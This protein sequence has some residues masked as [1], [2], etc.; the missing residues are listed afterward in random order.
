MLRFQKNLIIPLPSVRECTFFLNNDDTFIYVSHDKYKFELDRFY[1]GPI[2]CLKEHK[3]I[4]Y[5][6][7]RDGG[8]TIIKTDIGDLYVPTPFKKNEDSYAIT[9]DGKPFWNC[10]ELSYLEPIS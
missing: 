4:D 3:I 7:Y 6:T 9:F 10:S 1:I 8:T 2:D 5:V